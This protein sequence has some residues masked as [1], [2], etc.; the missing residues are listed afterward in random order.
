M[1]FNWSGK[2]VHAGAH[3]NERG[4]GV[5]EQTIEEKKP[6]ERF[7]SNKKSA[8]RYGPSCAASATVSVIVLVFPV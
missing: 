4:A 3:E 5:V 6:K 2:L 7:R 1:R 8:P